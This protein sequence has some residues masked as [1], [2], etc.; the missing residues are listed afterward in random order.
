[1]KHRKGAKNRA[2]IPPEILAGLTM[3]Q[4]ASVNLVEVLAVD[5]PALLVSIAPEIDYHQATSQLTDVQGKPLGITQRMVISS[6]ILLITYGTLT[7]VLN[8]FQAHPSDTVRGWVCYA[9]AQAENSPLSLTERLTLLQP[10][11]N[12]EHFGVREW[13]WLAIRSHLLKNLAE[14][15][16]L[17]TSW[18][19]TDEPNLRR[20]A[21]E[22][23]RPR[24]VWCSHSEVLKQQPELAL[25]I[26]K[27]LR[28]DKVRYVQDSVGN[29]LNDASKTQ[30]A[31]VQS[32]CSQWLLES[33]T[34]E[35]R[36]IC[37]KALRSLETVILS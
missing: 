2:A 26:L 16:V 3:G 31:W 33:P 24:G 5:F 35:T 9:I 27:P 21:S 18:A 20:F 4:L 1:V 23:L 17:L 8:R 6:T 32:L 37:K 30:P 15:I 22:A 28:C 7:E 25:P 10:L 14:A 11:A 36:Y 19:K 13:A 12:D 29:W 34:A